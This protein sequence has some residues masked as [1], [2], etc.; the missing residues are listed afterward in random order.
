[1]D[2]AL[3]IENLKL[4]SAMTF[5]VLQTMASERRFLLGSHHSNRLATS[6]G[7]ARRSDLC[8]RT[9]LTPSIHEVHADRL[10]KRYENLWKKIRSEALT[11]W[12]KLPAAIRPK[13]PTD[14]EIANQHLRFLTVV[15]SV[16]AVDA[17]EAVRACIRL[18]D[19]L[20]TTVA[21]TKGIGCLGALEVEVVSLE[22]MQ[23]FS[24]VDITTDSEQRKLDVCKTLA[25][26][27]TSTLYASEKSLFLIHFHGVV[28]AKRES[29]FENLQEKLNKNTSWTKAH[30]QIMMSRLS[31]QYGGKFKSV[32]QNLTHIATY[33]TKGG[34]DWYAKKAYLR[35]KIGFVNDDS[36]VTSEDM[37]MAKNWRR[38]QL[39]KEEHKIEGI[40]DPLSLT[41]HEIAQLA[42]TID[43]LM[44]LNNTRTGYLVSIL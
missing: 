29:Q 39:L 10:A 11:N 15:D 35:Y 42:I 21:S 7:S 12:R 3:Q 16:T 23:K 34:N 14:S 36:L 28:T 5:E 24:E 8:E 26:D 1:M 6:L 25:K 17:G 40:D 4:E 44:G 33:I 38:N 31:T 20:T 18:K 30:R 27:L 37:W 41:M 19:E 13:E 22:L 2:S 9:L 32:I 43:G